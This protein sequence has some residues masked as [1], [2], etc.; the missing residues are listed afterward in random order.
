MLR[1]MSQPSYAS[2]RIPPRAGVGLKAEHLAD[3]AENP[4]GVAF[5]EVHAEDYAG[6]GGAPHAA[7]AVIRDRFPLALHSSGLTIGGAKPL[8]RPYLSRLQ[9][10][11]ALYRPGLFSAR[12]GRSARGD[13]LADRSP[14]PYDEATLERV[15]AHVEQVQKVLGV[16]MLLENPS[17]G[18][19]DSATSETEFLSEVVAR[20]GCGLLLDLHNVHVAAA[21][22]GFDPFEYLGSFPVAAVEEIRF[23]RHAA[24]R[25]LGGVT[26][27]HRTHSAPAGDTVW[28]LYEFAIERT[29][30]V[31]T[32]IEWDGVPAY[33]TLAAEAARADD[34][35]ERFCVGSFKRI[36]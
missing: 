19:E 17:T 25:V 21:N 33:P 16:R 29:G 24:A 32:L 9:R 11:A 34:V 14:L 20:T 15:V 2:H 3:I 27:A 13:H 35:M 23:G 6:D 18:S 30:P 4:R 12:F 5:F 31:P 22:R 7:L 1:P 26:L 10:L 36:A 8:D 28:A